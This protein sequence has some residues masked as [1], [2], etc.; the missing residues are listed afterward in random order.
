MPENARPTRIAIVG[1][2]RVGAT[3]AYT[4]V[5]NGLAPEIVLI[6]PQRERTEGEAMDLSH[7]VPFTRPA[8][9]WAGDYDD[10]AG[11][12][13]TVITAGASQRPGESRLDLVRRNDAIL[14]QI[15]PKIAAANPDGLILMTTNPVDVLTHR[16]WQISGLPP[17][18]V[19]GSGTILDTARFRYLL[20]ERL[21]V[22]PRSMHAFIIGEHGDS[23]VPVWSGANIAGMRLEDYCATNGIEL[24][25]GEMRAIFEQT[26]DAAYQIIERKGATFYAIGAGLLRICEAIVRD[27]HTV[28]SVSCMIRGYYG[29]EDV[30]L[31]VPAVIHAGGVGRILR[32]ALSASEAEALRRS[33]GILQQTLEQLDPAPSA[34]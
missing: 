21:G 29:I 18:R 34:G 9:I 8:R 28:M 5:I 22:D 24:D 26:R 4:L 25:R 17:E 27:Q 16:A 15:V 20:A 2:G 32:P 1:A 31:S 11:A 10:C 6:D 13:L 19:F 23:E 14:Q 33:A 12:V 30:Y 7:A 3:F